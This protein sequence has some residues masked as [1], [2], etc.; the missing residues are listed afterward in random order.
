MM[1]KTNSRKCTMAIVMCAVLLM[2]S[3]CY[4][5]YL[6]ALILCGMATLV[7]CVW[8]C[9]EARVDRA[10]APLNLPTKHVY[11]ADKPPEG[12]NE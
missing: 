12:G 2:M 10:A 9:A 5:E 4:D 6:P 11:R 1:R 8:I 7:A 3:M